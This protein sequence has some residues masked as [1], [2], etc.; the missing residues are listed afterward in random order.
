MYKI[1]VN[2]ID[3]ETEHKNQQVVVNGNAIDLDLIPISENRFHI[4]LEHKSYLAEVLDLNYSQKLFKIKVNN[5][6]YNLEITDE[7]DALLKNLGLDNLNSNRLKEIK[8]PMPG[9]VLKI[10]V[11]AESEVKKGDNLLVLEAMKMENIIKA[12]ADFIVKKVNIK[13]GDKVEK[14]QVMLILD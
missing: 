12:P 9:L 1:K 11:E 14:N 7:Y 6:V 3:F 2:G 8:A 10:L 13:A 4:I 5:S